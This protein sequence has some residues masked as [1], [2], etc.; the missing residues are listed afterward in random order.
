MR[1]RHG[2]A[3]M[4][5]LLGALGSMLVGCGQ[6]SDDLRIAHGVSSLEDGCGGGAAFGFQDPSCK[7][8]KVKSEPGGNG[9]VCLKPPSSFTEKRS[10]RRAA[11]RN[12]CADHSSITLC[13]TTINQSVMASAAG[14]SL[15]AFA[16]AR[17]ATAGAR[18]DSC[19]LS[20]ARETGYANGSTDA[21]TNTM[22][23]RA[24]RP[25]GK[26]PS[27][28]VYV[29]VPVNAP[30]LV[31]GTG[32]GSGSVSVSVGDYQYKCECAVEVER[33]CPHKASNPP[34]MRTVKCSWSETSG[35][36]SRS[37]KDAPAC[38]GATSSPRILIPSGG[39]VTASILVKASANVDSSRFGSEQFSVLAHA[40]VALSKVNVDG[41]DY[42][43][44]LTKASPGVDC[45]GG[46]AD[47]DVD[48]S[49]QAC[50]QDLEECMRGKPSD[51]CLKEKTP[52]EIEACQK[53]E[54]VKDF[55]KCYGGNADDIAGGRHTIT[56][57]VKYSC[58]EACP[59]RGPCA[60][61]DEPGEDGLCPV[62]DH[63]YDTAPA[64][65]KCMGAQ[66]IEEKNASV[67]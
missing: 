62:T 11:S 8:Q 12:A 25:D 57:G 53:S 39:E 40:S 65:P 10:G 26:T 18:A 20:E 17:A 67:N 34:G 55:N 48:S 7:E 15:S 61:G 2:V 13:A 29:N 49:G 16:I 32:E 22:T 64:A 51:D 6:T 37:G 52:A 59:A 66:V 56:A 54:C 9:P 24:Q 38:V 19:Q 27:R 36:V 46:A 3:A 23:Y 35:G 47:D 58:E 44:A 14:G 33:A 1:I 4:C 42:P 21:T 45:G 60:A 50:F 43:F 30:L 31:T 63:C 5:G 41:V 28:A